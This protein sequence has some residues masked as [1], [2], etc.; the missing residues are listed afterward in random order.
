ME[1]NDSRL[2][3]ASFLLGLLGAPM[4]AV[5]IFVVVAARADGDISFCFAAGLV[6]AA[7]VASLL[8]GTFGGR[9]LITRAGL[10]GSG[11]GLLILLAGGFLLPTSIEWD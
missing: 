3:A 10:V 1:A 6:F 5:G 11:L 7:A 8:V 4:L 2:A 9:D